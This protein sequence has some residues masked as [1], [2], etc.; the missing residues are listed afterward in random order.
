[1]SEA[2]GP[3]VWRGGSDG[4][5]A[6]E[7]RP[8][9]TRRDAL[10]GVCGF[11]LVGLVFALD[12]LSGYST[13]VP[14]LYAG[15]LAIGRQMSWRLSIL[16]AALLCYALTVLGFVL[17]PAAG[18]VDRLMSLAVIAAAAVG[19][20]HSRAG[21]E[22]LA[23]AVAESG[24]LA[25]SKSRFLTAAGHDLRH[26]L[27][28]G[29]LFHDLLSRRLNG[30]SHEELV[31]GLGRA[32]EMQKRMLDGLLEVSH[33]DAGQVE[34]NPV[35]CSLV[36]LFERLEAEFAPQAAQA[37]L[38]LAVVPTAALVVT[39]PDLLARILRNLLDN[40]LKY[41]PQGG[42]V[43]GCRRCG[44]MVRIQVWDS[45]IGIPAER[46]HEVFEEFRQLRQ[47]ARDAGKGVG[48]GL[49]VAERLAEV[50]G[51]PLG[52]RSVVGRGSV[53]EVVVPLAEG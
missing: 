36:A 45:G 23:E 40:A 44:R 16:V 1:M 13:A 49:T 43:V 26:P 6:L 33:L 10:A 42:V 17:A 53:F 35:C 51:H 25:R 8:S 52:V 9:W 50:I 37:G 41:T 14:V 28:A 48:L 29:V 5:P 34:A 24:R 11:A 12:A 18:P 4:K 3:V 46:I 27:Q 32:L 21:S 30:S 47:L 38:K 15:A 22:A 2:L 7:A 39:D 20:R 19:L 31:T